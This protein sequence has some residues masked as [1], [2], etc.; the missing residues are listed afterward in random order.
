MKVTT[1]LFLAAIFGLVL[2]LTGAA[3]WV[4]ACAAAI[5]GA[6][7]LYALEGPGLPGLMDEPGGPTNE[8]STSAGDGVSTDVYIKPYEGPSRPSFTPGGHDDKSA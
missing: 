7:T 1:A 3:V 5:A 6:V 2:W 8:A 4:V